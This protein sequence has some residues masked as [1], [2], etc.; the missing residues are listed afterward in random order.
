MNQI[1]S[2]YRQTYHTLTQY[3][4]E[5]A[6]LLHFIKHNLLT[7]HHSLCITLPSHHTD[8]PHTLRLYADRLELKQHKGTA[9]CTFLNPQGE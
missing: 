8:L 4:E 5:T 6:Q 2:V 1:N 9:R 3:Q 7:T